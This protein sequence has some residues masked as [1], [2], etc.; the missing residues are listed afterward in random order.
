MLLN[1][2]FGGLILITFGINHCSSWWSWQR[3]ASERGC[4][5]GEGSFWCTLWCCW[6]HG[7]QS[8]QV[9]GRDRHWNWL[10]LGTVKVLM[11]AEEPATTKRWGLWWRRWC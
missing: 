4:P 8:P 9:V 7:R 6:C 2:H 5:N 10:C 3:R 1:L 11:G